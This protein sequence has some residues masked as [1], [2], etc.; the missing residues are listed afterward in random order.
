[1]RGG[2]ESTTQSRIYAAFQ[3]R[4]SVFLLPGPPYRRDHRLPDHKK[5]TI[6]FPRNSICPALCFFNIYDVTYLNVPQ[7]T[8]IDWPRCGD[9]GSVEG[10]VTVNA[11]RRLVHWRFWVLTNYYYWRRSNQQSVAKDRFRAFL[12]RRIFIKDNVIM[13][14]VWAKT[15]DVPRPILRC[16]IDSTICNMKIIVWFDSYILAWTKNE[17]FI[18]AFRFTLIFHRT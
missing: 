6:A 3:K 5:K 13:L 14:G 2:A 7:S 9:D 11:S 4:W 16:I 15:N 18:N 17:H 1:M 12:F 10:L 8:V